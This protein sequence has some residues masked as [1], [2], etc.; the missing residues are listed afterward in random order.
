MT[1]TPWDDD[2]GLLEELRAAVRQAGTPTPGM[3]AAA[4]AAFSW[5]TV[6]A[7]LAV[8]TEEAAAAETSLVRATSTAPRLLEFHT[9]QLSVELEQTESGLVG[10]LVPPGPGLVT[11]VGRGGELGRADADELGCFTLDSAPGELVRVRC[12]TPSAALVTEWFRL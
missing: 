5:R 10:Q 12:D 4:E 8:L 9:A 3:T 1:T 11:L 7:E 6:D 2:E